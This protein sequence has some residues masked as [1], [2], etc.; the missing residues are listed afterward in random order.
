[1]KRWRIGGIV[2]LMGLAATP[3]AAAQEPLV[4]NPPLAAIPLKLSASGHAHKYVVEVA[5]TTS[6]QARGLMLRKIMPRGHGM[7]FPMDPPR[8]AAFW[9]E[10][11]VLPLDL[12]FI[13]PDHRIRRIAA[14]A[15]PFDKT[16]IP[17]GG[18]VAAVLELNAGEA[19]RIGL[20][21][22][23]KVDYSLN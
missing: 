1:M 5:R 4:A 8:E 9:M 10:G 16:Q 22:G 7:I 2:A 23:D 12:V 6:E 17:S 18:V 15:V 11:T 21:S 3:P 14:N 19:A 20:H 13:A